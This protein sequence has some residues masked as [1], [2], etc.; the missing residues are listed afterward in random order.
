MKKNIISFLNKKN[1]LF[2]QEKLPAKSI[3]AK[4]YTKY[5]CW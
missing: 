4:K 2:F 5:V 3:V 1:F